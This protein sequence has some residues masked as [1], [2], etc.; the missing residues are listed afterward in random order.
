MKKAAIVFGMSFSIFLLLSFLFVAHSNRSLIETLRV[1]DESGQKLLLWEK[2]DPPL[3]S[4]I[5]ALK[6]SL[7]LSFT[8]GLFLAMG[9]SVFTFFIKSE[10]NPKHS[11]PRKCFHFLP[12]WFTCAVI[13]VVMVLFM[14]D[15]SIF[16]RIRDYILL[17]N[18]FGTAICET[19]YR[20]S[21]FA[22]C[23]IQSPLNKSIKTVWIDPRVP[24]RVFMARTLSQFGWYSVPHR[25]EVHFLIR[26]S[27][28]GKLLFLADHHRVMTVLPSDFM[29]KPGYWLKIYSDKQCNTRWIGWLC[30]G[31]LFIG[32]PITAIGIEYG[33]IFFM[34][35]TVLTK[36]LSNAISCTVILLTSA[37]LI[38]Y[39]YPAQWGNFD[40][41]IEK[42]TSSHSRERIEALRV[43][44]RKGMNTRHVPSNFLNHLNNYSS[45][46]KYW[47]A[48][49]IANGEKTKNIDR[50]SQFLNNSE[51]AVA[52]AAIT[53]LS[54]NGCSVQTACI[55]RQAANNRSEWYIQLKL[56][57]AMKN[58]HGK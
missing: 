6:A 30:L 7:L 33:I 51:I 18:S 27:D 38:I 58:C 43:I 47:I 14:A 1:L 4:T 36:T 17:S 13:S 10:L 50:L 12:L 39:L 35:S 49:V 21:P 11:L 8:G 3:D 2:L 37:L 48:K 57:N 31:G 55:L 9:I 5:S 23:A 52:S 24:K 22:A 32:L 15:G 53:S 45:A 16:Q 46:E 54:Q 44:Y 29:A 34:L 19:Y 41:P 28:Q 56:L 25:K 20:Y 42:L 26:L 40:R